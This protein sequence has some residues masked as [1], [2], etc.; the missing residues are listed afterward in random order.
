MSWEIKLGWETQLESEFERRKLDL[1]EITETE[2][3]RQ[4][5]LT[6]DCCRWEVWSQVAQK[7]Q[8]W[9]LAVFC[10]KI[11]NGVSSQKPEDNA[12][13]KGEMTGAEIG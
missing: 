4:K 5:E 1:D 11:A 8:F 3:F 10:G 9:W 6:D 2:E 13:E 12:P 7:S